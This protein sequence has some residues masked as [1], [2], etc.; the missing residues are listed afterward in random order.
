MQARYCFDMALRVFSRSRYVHLTLATLEKSVGNWD[1]A[2]RLMVEGMKLNPTDAALPQVRCTDCSLEDARL[3]VHPALELCHAD[4]L[5]VRV[6]R[7]NFYKFFCQHINMTV[8]VV[9]VTSFVLLLSR[10]TVQFRHPLSATHA[11]DVL[12]ILCA[13][14][15][16]L[17]TTHSYQQPGDQQ[18]T[19]MQAYGLLLAETGNMSGAQKLFKRAISLDKE[20]MHAWQAW[21]VLHAR[22]GEYKVARG[23]FRKAV[24][25]N[26]RH[27][28][29]HY[30]WHVRPR[31]PIQLSPALPIR[32]C[33]PCP[34]DWRAPT[35]LHMRMRRR[36]SAFAAGTACRLHLPSAAGTA[37]AQATRKQTPDRFWHDAAAPSDQ[38]MGGC[39]LGRRW[40]RNSATY[41]TRAASIA[42]A[43]R[44]VPAEQICWDSW[45]RLETEANLLQRAEQVLLHTSTCPAPTSEFASAACC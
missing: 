41:R 7:V 33:N 30:I 43:C 31:R 38:Q 23:I 1:E 27:R 17:G 35:C 18:R 24:E 13:S 37:L 45:V 32:C 36:D 39:R 8:A 14:A 15:P 22:L 19:C 16:M 9:L 34:S 3:C 2:A 28:S 12:S 21:G 26:G 42:P 10:P 40:R 5:C 6:P 11:A 29:L 25:I 4:V 44:P 20:M